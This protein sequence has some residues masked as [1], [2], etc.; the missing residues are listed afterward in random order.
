MVL[1]SSEVK[2]HGSQRPIAGQ[3]MIILLPQQCAAYRPRNLKLPISTVLNFQAE[4]ITV[5][6]HQRQWRG[7]ELHDKLCFSKCRTGGYFEVSHL[8]DMIPSESKTVRNNVV[9]LSCDIHLHSSQKKRLPLNISFTT[10]FKELTQARIK[11]CFS[12]PY[13]SLLTQAARMPI[14][15]TSSLP[16]IFLSPT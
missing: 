11:R 9:S 16:S 2:L 3:S 1:T 10:G 7:Y 8:A 14:S 15:T 5:S 12:S 6:P 4:S 13:H